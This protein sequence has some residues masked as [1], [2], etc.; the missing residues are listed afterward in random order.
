MGLTTCSLML[1]Q[2]HAQRQIVFCWGSFAHAGVFLEN[3]V[4]LDSLQFEWPLT[5]RLH[6]TNTV[7]HSF[8]CNIWSDFVSYRSALKHQYSGVVR[9]CCNCNPYIATVS[10]SK[11]INNVTCIV[12]WFI[13]ISWCGIYHKTGIAIIP[14]GALH[15]M[16][17]QMCLLCTQ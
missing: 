7:R 1:N 3:L 11:T 4:L 5:H 9:M 17:K 14:E 6:Y 8:Y 13:S 12:I 2:T 16:H 15:Q 10:C